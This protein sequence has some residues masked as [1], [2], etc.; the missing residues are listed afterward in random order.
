MAAVTT[1]ERKETVGGEWAKLF[2]PPEVDVSTVRTYNHKF[3]PS[4]VPSQS[5]SFYEFSIGSLGDKFLVLNSLQLYL[6]GRMVREDGQPIA[7]DEPVALVNNALSSLFKAVNLVL[8]RNQLEV[9]DSH[10]PHTSY[11]KTLTKIQDDVSSNKNVG[12]QI[13]FSSPNSGP[14]EWNE[15]SVVRA[16]WLKDAP[17]GYEMKGKLAIDLF[18]TG[19]YLLPRTP[20]KLTLIRS[21]PG[22]Y[23]I[24]P[25]NSDVS[26]TFVVDDL[27][28]TAFS[29]DTV[30]EVRQKIADILTGSSEVEERDVETDRVLSKRQKIDPDNARHANYRFDSIVTRYHTVPENQGT[31]TFPNIFGDGVVPRK[32]LIGFTS[33]ASWGGNDKLNPFYF[34][35]LNTAKVTVLLDDQPVATLS[36]DFT[37]GFT[38]DLFGEFLQWAGLENAPSPVKKDNFA[39]GNTFFCY[40]A[41]K[42]CSEAKHCVQELMQSGQLSIQVD[43]KEPVKEPMI[44]WVFGTR[45]SDMTV[46]ADGNVRLKNSTI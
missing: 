16:G 4:K 45:A 23:I 17:K 18:T 35:H 26:Y 10:Y 7:R 43:F 1:Q 24:K 46:D 11:I 39:W 5:D 44:M 8:G 42:N 21:S 33:Q 40:D 36:A 34:H 27:Y 41:M 25:Q 31:T 30:R 15:G 3:Y 6:R 29:I 13:D 22:F 37:N 20:L 2:S 14:K 9:T 32:L 28:M 12:W 19:S 38:V